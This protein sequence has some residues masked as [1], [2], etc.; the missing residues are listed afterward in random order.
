MKQIEITEQDTKQVI[1]VYKLLQ[2]AKYE[3]KGD[4]VGMAAVA[5]NWVAELAKRMKEAKEP[6]PVEESKKG[7]K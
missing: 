3:I 2:E 1:I 7:R 5:M 4:A 6:E